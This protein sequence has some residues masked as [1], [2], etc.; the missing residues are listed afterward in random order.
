MRPS[1]AHFPCAPLSW[2][3]CTEAFFKAHAA[4]AVFSQ[5]DLT[6]VRPPR[7]TANASPVLA[8]VLAQFTT[9]FITPFLT[10]FLTPFAYVLCLAPALQLV[11]NLRGECERAHQLLAAGN[12]LRGDG[13]GRQKVLLVFPASPPLR[14]ASESQGAAVCCGR[15]LMFGLL[16]IRL[17]AACRAPACLSRVGRLLIH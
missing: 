10:P 3:S 12:K 15:S 11:S 17:S 6:Q 1:H 4:Q 7:S 2:Q 16:N 14:S 5:S 13:Y 8:P 9:Q